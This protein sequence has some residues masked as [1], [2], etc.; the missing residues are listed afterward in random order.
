MNIRTPE[1]T[2]VRTPQDTGVRTPQ[3]T[4]VRTPSGI[5]VPVV[6]TGD[7]LA[8]TDL[9]QPAT[10]PFTRG[11]FADGFRGRP[12]TIRQY[13]GFGSAEE[14][15]EHYHRINQIIPQL[16]PEDHYKIDEK[17]KNVTMTEDGVFHVEK[18]LHLDNLYDDRNIEILHHV[19]QGLRAHVLF[20]REVDYIVKEGKV[21][22]VDEFTGRLMPGRRWSDGLH[23]AIEAKEGVEIEEEN[24]TMATVTLQNYFRMYEKL[25][26]MT[27]TAAT[28]AQEFMEI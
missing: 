2:S 7:M 5:E 16:K 21:L 24:Q 12:W 1:D 18:L 26:G 23:Q 6:A 10:Y 9:E 15:T 25:A 22:I 27:G 8:R 11:I 20:K 13:S 4:G 14:S 3:D 17:H 19:V 28:E